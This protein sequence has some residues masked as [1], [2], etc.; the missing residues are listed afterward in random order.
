[1]RT[2]LLHPLDDPNPQPLQANRA[3]FEELDCFKRPKAR[4]RDIQCQEYR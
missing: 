4:L 3:F 2:A 1:M